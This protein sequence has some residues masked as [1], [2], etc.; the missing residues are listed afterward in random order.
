MPAHAPLVSISNRQRD[1]RISVPALRRWTV[2]T[3]RL[4]QSDAELGIHLVTPV[5]MADVNWRFLRHSGSTDVITFDHGSIPGRLHGELFISI[6]DAVAQAR[7]FQTTWQQELGRYVIHGLLH[8]TGEDDLEPGARRRMKRREDQLFL[9]VD[10][11]LPASSLERP[12]PTPSRPSR[13]RHG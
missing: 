13:P 5:E 11:L 3:L 9:N 12:S 7:S 4:L 10:S 2:A 1:R 6:A 8:L